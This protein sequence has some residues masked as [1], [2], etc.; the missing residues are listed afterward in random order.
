MTEAVT[1]LLY[2]DDDPALRR[3][4]ERR[5]RNGG[6]VVTQAAD[7]HEGLQLA[8][9]ATFDVVAVDHHMPG[10]D[11][12][13][14]LTALR[15]LPDCPP[16]VYVTGADDGRLAVAALRAGADDYVVK[17]VGEDFI[18]LLQTAFAQA[19]DR[20]RLR[21]A[22]ERAEQDLIAS[23]ERLAALLREVNHRV[24]NNLQMTMSFIGMQASVL[25]EGEARNALLASQQRIGAIAQV[26]R[27]LYATGN[28]ESV[29]MDDYLPGLA[30]DLADTWSTP[31]APRRVIA[32]ADAVELQT[33]Q[34]VTLGIII[35][36][37]VANSCK[38]AYPS[39]A[40]GDIRVFLQRM[41][42]DGGMLLT[43]E[44]D[45]LGLCSSPTIKGTGLGQKLVKAMARGLGTVP[46]I[47]PDHKG[48]RVTIQFK[49]R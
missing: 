30:R 42:E 43:V 25:P 12:M 11:G 28:V 39:D 10:M 35:C 36:E 9:T 48:L 32:H 3:L 37:L 38:Y 27:H 2:I 22:K 20:V 33:D 46:Q 40:S 6:Y 47:D 15:A 49:L 13:E 26:N 44:D 41:D 24:A 17:T 7:G 23:N 5:L 4:V 31:A 1:R 16:I 18:E 19:L 34:A 21:K 29:A 14:T 45:G 8:A